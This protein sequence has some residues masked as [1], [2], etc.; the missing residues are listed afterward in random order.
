MGWNMKIEAVSVC[1]DYAD[2][3]AHTILWNRP[4]FDKWV[5]VTASHDRRTRDICEH[6]HIECVVTDSF[7]DGDRAFVKSNGINAGLERL[8]RDGW[9]AHLDAD[10]VL[11]PRA[12]EL[13]ERAQL[14]PKGIYGCDRICCESY[15]EW[16]QYVTWPEVQHSVNAF[17]QANAFPLGARVA[18]LD[19]DGWSPIGF[20]QLWHPGESLARFY[21]DHG[22]AGRSDLIFGRS[23]QRRDRH[24]LPEIVAVHLS[25][26]SDGMGN[27]WRG[28]KTPHFGP[29]PVK[30]IAAAAAKPY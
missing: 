6:H 19:G 16:A 11:P 13:I 5:V 12:R 8:S 14:D 10:I 3:L 2:F 29:A 21:P 20:F 28:R 23:W 4:Q 24:L 26:G 17:V 7:Y 27:N 25:S 1:V 9:V 18:Q 15:E 22:D 30:A